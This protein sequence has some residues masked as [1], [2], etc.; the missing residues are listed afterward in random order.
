MMLSILG[1]GRLQ[2]SIR[3]GVNH[4]KKEDYMP[5]KLRETHSGVSVMKKVN[6]KWSELHKYTGKDAY[7]KAVKYLRALYVHTKD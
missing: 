2:M 6:G 1:L 7:D 4:A 5:Y 3:L